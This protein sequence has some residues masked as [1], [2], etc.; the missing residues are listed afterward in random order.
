ML[1]KL[2]VTYDFEAML[3]RLI[4][5]P[6]HEGLPEVLDCANGRDQDHLVG[7]EDLEVQHRL[8]CVVHYVDVELQIL[9]VQL[10][11]QLQ[12]AAEEA[13]SRGLVLEPEDG[14]DELGELLV[15][16][17]L[18]AITVLEVFIGPLDQVQASS[19]IVALF[20]VLGRDG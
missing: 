11:I 13:E 16:H 1:D 18:E 7:L 10:V 12:E 20:L 17:I 8:E 5:Q 14:A 2:L 19:R 15:C 3:H 9:L 4:G 6:L